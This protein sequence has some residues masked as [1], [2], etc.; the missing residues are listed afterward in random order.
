MS[1]QRVKSR[2]GKDIELATEAIDQF[3]SQLRGDL[4]GP[5]DADYEEARQV[6]NAMHDRRPA[7]IA[8]ATGVADVMAAVDFARQHDLLLAVRG[9]G[10][11]VPGFGTC[12]GGLVID[13]GRMKGIRVD[14]ERA[15]VRA[16]GGCTWGDFNHATQAFGLATPG[17]IVSTTGIAGLTLGGGIGYLGRQFGLSCDNLVSADVVT[18][19]GAFVTC[20]EDRESDLF[21]AIRGGGGN[22]GVVTSFEYKLHPVGEI[23]GGVSFYR[24]EAEVLENYLALI[25][26][27]PEEL[28]AVFAFAL[29]PPLPFVPDDWHSKPVTAVLA[30]W[31]G[32]REQDETIAA[33]LSGLGQVVG[34]A[35]WRM[36]YPVIN[37]LFDELLPR[38]LRHYWKANFAREV[39]DAAV[40][41]HA[42][43][44]PEVPTL[45]SGTFIM[46]IDGA[47]HHVAPGD[48]AFAGRESAFSVVIAGTWKDPADDAANIRWVRDYY[49]ALK[50]YSEAGGYINFMSGDD[51]DRAPDN[52][53]ANYLR[54]REIKAKVDPNNLFSLNQNVPPAE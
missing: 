51:Q 34:Q 43:H 28:G 39:S 27:A 8:R 15:T 20:D 7:L 30:T 32:A 13:L 48:T 1:T 18:A 24:A 38:G 42:A 45:E 50:P 33:K 41:V 4:I 35:L 23:F 12:D 37:T 10:H 3:K 40:A 6:Y 26:D 31:N 53:G 25:A 14:P 46:P 9:G 16:E 17:G 5:G 36:P 22:F 47:C 54:L 44:G 29:A 19:D 21:W 2:H 11:S 49:D 52:F